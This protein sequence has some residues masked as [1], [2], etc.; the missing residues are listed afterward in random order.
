MTERTSLP[1]ED[2][3]QALIS[4]VLPAHNEEVGISHAFDVIGRTLDDCDVRWEIIAV[5]DGS[6]DQTFAVV[7][8]RARDDSR[9][10]GIHFSRNF[11]KEAAL[12]AG[13]DAARG[14]AVITMDADL[15]HPPSVI[16]QMLDAWRGG[17][18][19][20]HGVKRQRQHDSAATRL[21]AW[22][23][24]KTISWL[25]GI[26]IQ[27]SSDFKLMDR[28][29]VDVIT[30]QLPERRRF[31]RGLAD[32][33]GYR[34]VEIPFDV[35]ERSD[36]EGRWSLLGLV[37]LA[38]TALVSFTSA[39]LRIVTLMGLLT[40]ALGLGLTVETLWSWFQ[41]RAVSGFATMILTLLIIGSFIMISLG[42]IGEYIAKIYEEVKARPAYLIDEY[43]DL[44]TKI[45]D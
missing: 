25:G 3:A 30:K 42:I 36:G 12:M 45:G 13:I 1:G 39:P 14:D 5:D 19:V 4:V 43:T 10:R 22:I 21:R 6:Q 31:F 9:I 15:Q 2:F 8:Q 44:D 38:L 20:A 27:N 28:V 40:L 26:N 32:W 7:S 37:E 24:N 34:N 17:A 41:G 11:G 23:F 16:P 29:V 35:A 33:V 18:K